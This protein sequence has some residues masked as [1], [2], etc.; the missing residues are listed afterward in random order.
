MQ[1]PN[2]KKVK[3]LVLGGYGY[4]GTW[5]SNYLS[6][7]GLEVWRQGRSTS[8]QANFDVSNK[9]VFESFIKLHKFDVIVNLIAITDLEFCEQNADIAMQVNA[10]LVLGVRSILDSMPASERP[11][12]IQISTDQVY[13][14]PG[15]HQED[16][17]MPI[18]VYGATKLAGEMYADVNKSTILRVN[19]I[20]K[21]TISSRVSLSDW[22]V[23][24]ARR[25]DPVCLYEDVIFSPLHISTL[26]MVICGVV[27]N[28]ICG[29]FNL[30]ASTS[31]D[32]ASY[33]F[34]LLELIGLST[35]NF[36][37]VKLADRTSLV[38]RPLDM[39]IGVS[40]I[41]RALGFRLPSIESQIK[42]NASEYV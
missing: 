38:K 28:P 41:E 31:I 35:R 11:H 32:K 24:S 42:L 29:V 33:A 23:N 1:V 27:L 3:V 14:G 5:L 22:V 8:S 10:L 18:N 36:S 34:K 12:F 25:E 4:L 21:S 2:Q 16:E 40:K 30:G 26:C 17:T 6:A 7:N 13:S 39:S 20:G 19:F 37:K 9:D 15:P